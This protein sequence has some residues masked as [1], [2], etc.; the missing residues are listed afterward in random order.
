M[1][2]LF[3]YFVIA[4]LSIGLL[5]LN[6]VIPVRAASAT[7][8]FDPVAS[9]IGLGE[10]GKVAVTVNSDVPVYSIDVTIS[11]PT[12][13]VLGVEANAETSV[14]TITLFP[15]TVDNSRGQARFR[16]AVP[17]PGATGKHTIG[18]LLFR[19]AALGKAQLSIVS[20]QVIGYDE[21]N[22]TDINIYQGAST[23]TI[24][25]TNTKK[26]EFQ[27]PGE[28]GPIPVVNSTSHPDPSKWYSNRNI[29]FTWG[30]GDKDYIWVFDQDAETL[31]P[32]S[33]KG[34]GTTTTISGVADGVWYFHVRAAKEGVWGPTSTFKVQIDGTAPGSFSLK[35]DPDNQ[36]DP[37]A[38]PLVSF[39]APDTPS[40]ID[41]Y[42]VQLDD[43]AWVNTVSPY[44]VP[45][46][47]PGAHHI[48]VRAVDRAGNV[49]TASTDFTLKPITPTP[50]ITTPENNGFS[51]VMGDEAK[52]SG[53]AV[54]DSSVQ[55][56][57]DGQFVTAVTADKEGKFTFVL[58]N[59]LEPGD[60][61]FKVKST[62]ARHISSEYSNEIK[63]SL[64]A[65]GTKIGGVPVPDWVIALVYI[66][67]V[68]ILIGVLLWLIRKWLK[69]QRDRKLAIQKL[70][71]LSEQEV[72]ASPQPTDVGQ[73]PAKAEG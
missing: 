16:V 23:G 45:L 35:L 50:K 53:T 60:Y 59:Q 56:Y 66:I 9:Q 32:T 40:G 20:A 12:G 52:I 72:P 31:P 1:K 70:E 49:T 58:R 27:S 7:I 29:T 55:L 41:H 65:S 21:A 2:R 39:D 24:E 30:G 73:E 28:L 37:A 61:T 19:G 64:L 17:R 6:G 43:A 10:T 36:K 68:L 13:T 5:P 15:S 54:P 69:A 14:F 47:K 42:E 57:A 38:L 62:M 22:G 4:L 26:P 71:L 63:G 3:R 46:L 34:G 51:L 8:G 11:Y 67:I 18:T 48:N 44:Q 33:S 25:V